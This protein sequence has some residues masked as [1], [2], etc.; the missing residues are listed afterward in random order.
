MKDMNWPSPG[1]A[2]KTISKSTTTV[3]PKNSMGTKAAPMVQKSRCA[4]CGGGKR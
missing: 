1:K 3:V 4:S 2:V